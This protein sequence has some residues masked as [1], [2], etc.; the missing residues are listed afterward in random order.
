M[1]KCALD[2]RERIEQGRAAKAHA[3]ALR[4]QERR[5]LRRE[6]RRQERRDLRA[7]LAAIEDAKAGMDVSAASAAKG[8]DGVG[9]VGSIGGTDST[10]GVDAMSP[11]VDI[12]EGTAVGVAGGGTGGENTQEGGAECSKGRIPISAASVGV[13]RTVHATL[14]A[15]GGGTETQR[16]VD[17]LCIASP[18]ALKS[19]SAARVGTPGTPGEGPWIEVK[20]RHGKTRKGNQ[21]SVTDGRVLGTPESEEKGEGEHGEH[22]ER[23]SRKDRKDRKDRKARAERSLIPHRHRHES[24][25]W[26]GGARVGWSTDDTDTESDTGSDDGSDSHSEFTEDNSSEDE[27]DGVLGRGQG[28]P[29]AEHTAVRYFL[30]TCDALAHCHAQGIVHRDVKGQN[31]FL[32]DEDDSVRLGDF[33]LA[34]KT[35]GA[36]DSRYSTGGTD[37]YKPPESL[38]GKPLEW[39]RVDVWGLGLFLYEIIALKFVW[40]HDGLIGAKVIEKGFAAVDELLKGLPCSTTGCVTDAIRSMLSP[41]PT[42]RPSVED[43]I[44][45]L[46]HYTYPPES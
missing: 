34:R 25:T 41:S 5:R 20:V 39:K 17:P 13:D 2:M 45:S 1:E 42:E 29:L 10:G 15:D 16:G 24:Y 28:E 21:Q 38:L 11:A 9:G 30:E 22:K 23:T 4:R 8:S 40:E 35:M 6:H 12:A 26:I 18:K 19:S 32:T 3:A 27:S 44:T 33:G 14:P 36:C 46:R 43:V 7:R 37:V 31:V